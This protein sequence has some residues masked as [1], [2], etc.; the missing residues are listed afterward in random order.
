[1]GII[2]PLLLRLLLPC[3]PGDI[4]YVAEVEDGIFEPFFKLEVSIILNAENGWTQAGHGRFCQ[5]DKPN[6]AI[7]LATPETTDKIC[8]P[9]RTMGRVSCARKG[10]AVINLTRWREGA[11][12]W[13]AQSYRRYIINHE[14][15]HLLE[16]G[17]RKCP[18][19]GPTP[20]MKQQSSSKIN[21]SRSNIPTQDEIGSMTK[22]YWKFHHIRKGI[23]E[24]PWK[25]P[26]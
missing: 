10:R 7:L 25:R 16:M 20:V 24:D 1:M 9:M 13:D 8:L 17:H 2:L 4:Q 5:S 6:F 15:G 21:C 26:E 22:K 14:V 12:G 19:F 3:Q 11:P 18:Y 23:I